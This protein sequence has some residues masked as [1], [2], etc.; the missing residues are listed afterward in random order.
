MNAPQ[1]F[2]LNL[3]RFVR[4]PREK[5]FD[6]FVDET[7]L[8]R[9]HCPR[10]MSVASATIDARV[11][12]AWRIEMRTRENANHSVGG[13]YREVKRAE[14]LVYTWVWEQGVEGMA[15]MQ[16]LI[17][18][19]FVARDG[20]TEIQM[21][22]SGFPAAA[23]R[24][25]HG[26]GW[27][28]VFNRLTDLLD[29]RGSAA[30]LTLL[31]DAASTYVRSARIGLAEKGLAYTFQRAAPHSPEINAVHPFGKMPAF[32]D[33]TTEIWETS[34]ILR[35]IDEGFEGPSLNPGMVVDRARS[36]QWVSAVNAYV[37]D[38]MV[39][40]YV[41]QYVFPRGEGGTPDRGVIDKA[42]TDMARPL[43][44]LERCYE[45][46]DFVGGAAPS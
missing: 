10:G 18:I 31:G 13:R 20:G 16:T 17:E 21:R 8:P 2:T 42:V 5:V 39:R 9:W 38:A 27:N 14:R 32:R 36:E 3:T 41:L 24:N 30:T 12:G 7:V 29:E 35:Y 40:R 1:D 34:A 33:G 23:A 45:G 46:R 15:G 19:D 6:A 37:Y 28:S 44:A 11:D 22:H 4:A 43:G 25:G 26:Q